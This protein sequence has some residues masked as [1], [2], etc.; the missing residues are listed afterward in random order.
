MLGEELSH[1]LLASSIVCSCLPGRQQFV[2]ETIIASN[3]QQVNRLV[4]VAR[5]HWHRH[6]RLVLRLRLRHCSFGC[7]FSEEILD[8]TESVTLQKLLDFRLCL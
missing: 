1:G 7:P 2:Q 3:I 6:R 5:F 4:L 8:G